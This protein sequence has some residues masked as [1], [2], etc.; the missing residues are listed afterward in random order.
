MNFISQTILT[1]HLLL[2]ISG[3]GADLSDYER[4]GDFTHLKII[5]IDEIRAKVP[6]DIRGG[7]V[8]NYLD[9]FF[10]VSKEDQNLQ[11]K[12]SRIKNLGE[13][14]TPLGQ[15]GCFILINNFQGINIPQLDHPVV[16]RHPR[17]VAIVTNDS[18]D[19][20]DIDI[21]WV[22]HYLYP[23]KGGR[24]AR[25]IIKRKCKMSKLLATFWETGQY[26]NWDNRLDLC[27]RIIQPLFAVSAKPLNCDAE[28]GLFP[29]LK[30]Y[31]TE[32]LRPFKYYPR[33]FKFENWHWDRKKAVSLSRPLVHVIIA[34]SLEAASPETFQ[35]L[36]V[37]SHLLINFDTPGI[38]Q[39][40]FFLGAVAS[41]MHDHATSEQV[42]F[43]EYVVLVR[44]SDEN[45]LRHHEKEGYDLVAYSARQFK[46]ENLSRST[47]LT[48]SPAT[49]KLL[50]F[51]AESM[52]CV[53]TE[54]NYYRSQR[55]SKQNVFEWHNK[56]WLSA[57]GNHTFETTG[58]R[59]C[60]NG[61]LQ[62]HGLPGRVQNLFRLFLQC[63]VSENMLHIGLPISHIYTDTFKTLRFISCSTIKYE[64]LLFHELINIYDVRVWVSL[65]CAMVTLS[66]SISHLGRKGSFVGN[67]LSVFKVV[68]GQGDP[69]MHQ[70]LSSA[71]LRY[72]AATFLFMGIILS[73]GYKSS[74]MYRIISPR[75]IILKENLSELIND[76]FTV[77]T[78]AIKI[79]F[80]F[81]L[82]SRI[83]LVSPDAGKLVAT[84][85]SVAA[86]GVALANSEVTMT[87]KH[88]SIM[89]GSCLHPLLFP[90][91]KD[92][93]TEHQDLYVVNQ[94]KKFFRQEAKKSSIQF[95]PELLFWVMDNSN[96]NVSVS[97]FNS[98]Q[99]RRFTEIFDEWNSLYLSKH[100]A[101]AKMHSL[102]V[103]KFAMKWQESI[104]LEFLQ[105]CSN[106]ALIL[107]DYLIQEYAKRLRIKEHQHM[108]IGRETYPSIASGVFLEGFIPPVVIRRVQSIAASGV[109]DWHS[110][111]VH[112]L[113]VIGQSD[114]KPV[115]PKM[116][117]HVQLIFV[118][119]LAGVVISSVGFLTELL[120][121]RFTWIWMVT[122][123]KMTRPMIKYDVKAATKMMLKEVPQLILLQRNTISCTEN[124]DEE[125]TEILKIHP[126]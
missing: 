90:L 116:T 18:R 49:D 68:V 47:E 62:N 105:N 20:Y 106:A 126:R 121:Q 32:S 93:V 46:A 35:Q 115:T 94:F 84:K 100:E 16:L 113:H 70:V 31:E 76:N 109:W 85:H 12:A 26:R 124:C 51:R 17:L 71:P 123:S 104:L 66:L 42:S 87:S 72:A 7:G 23:P 114:N 110:A 92:L 119:L 91:M 1:L 75:Q 37:Y 55:I 29:N 59:L 58:G 10:R 6:N 81:D 77:Y 30:L 79:E 5:R 50:L 9:G 27:L 65:I 117:G 41:V 111:V 48:S 11:Q 3:G 101:D 82:T 80:A 67:M 45:A 64:P 95:D 38:P 125:C 98:D 112:K 61:V 73:E 96:H 107:P 74:N 97:V 83:K 103:N 122:L 13:Y 78:R 89:E 21:F 40:V 118:I 120:L 8:S 39:G 34:Q 86:Y 63:F 14:V 33:I 69:F 52:P 99:L 56:A 28:F 4:E 22:P 25:G 88:N 24:L 53:A 54:G 15:L 60:T 19:V 36:M 108:S 43:L 44:V 2:P 57:F 102:E